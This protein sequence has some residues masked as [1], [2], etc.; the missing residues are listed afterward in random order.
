MTTHQISS[1]ISFVL[2]N[3]GAIGELYLAQIGSFLLFSPNVFISFCII[4]NSYLYKSYYQPP[5]YFKT[6]TFLSGTVFKVIL[7][8]K[9][10]GSVFNV[11]Y[12]GM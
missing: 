4:S 1:I 11:H 6:A 2:K 9:G 12:F 7:E 8:S 5:L 3:P 10:F